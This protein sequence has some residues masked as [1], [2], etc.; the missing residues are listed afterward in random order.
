MEPGVTSDVLNNNAKKIEYKSQ[1]T[2]LATNYY[3]DGVPFVKGTGIKYPHPDYNS[4]PGWEV[5][6]NWYINGNDLTHVHIADTWSERIAELS[7]AIAGALIGSRAGPQAAVA[8]AILGLLLGGSASH[9]LLD[10]EGCIWYWYSPSW[11]MV[12]LPIPP[13]MHYLPEYFRISEY[14][15]W[16]ELNIGNP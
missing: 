10:E 12:F 5:W 9:A 3:W 8:G 11:G 4:Y 7:P 6:E 15:L 1:V 13:F 14:T 16:D 2:T